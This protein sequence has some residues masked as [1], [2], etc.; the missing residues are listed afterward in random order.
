MPVHQCARFSNQPMLSHEKAVKRIVKYLLA[1]ADRGVVFRLDKTCRVECYADADF[2]GNWSKHTSVNDPSTAKSRTGYIIKYANCPIIWASKLQTQIA[3]STTEAEYIALSTAL[4]EVIPLLALF[5]EMKVN[6]IPLFHTIPVIHCKAFEDNLGA[7]EMAKSPK[8][9]PP[10]KHINIIY[11]HSREQLH[12]GSIQLH[13]ISTNDQLADI[14]TKTLP[15]D[16]FV[17]L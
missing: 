7:L 1:T 13:S 16:K 3:L 14:C 8:M 11:H 9:R 5:E 12:T 17:P 10:T 2:S 15:Q 6:G 4:R